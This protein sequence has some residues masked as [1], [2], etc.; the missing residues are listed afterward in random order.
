DRD[1]LFPYDN[2]DDGLGWWTRMTHHVDGGYYGY[3]YDYHKLTDRML[4]PM[5]EYGG[6][7]PCGG[8]FYDEDAWPETYRGRLFWAEWGKRAVQALRL[9]SAGATFR[10]VDM[11]DFVQ[12]CDAENFRP[13]DLACSHEGGTLYIADWSSG[14][15]NNKTEKLGRVYAVTHPAATAVKV[16]PRGQDSDPIEVQV[17]QLGHSSYH[18]RTRAQRALT[19]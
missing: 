14:S 6:G 13:L 11:I 4:P 18:E 8:A 12:A 5:A 3:P 19:R 2:T 15:W 7:S 9:A 1:N 10:V 17:R 16:R